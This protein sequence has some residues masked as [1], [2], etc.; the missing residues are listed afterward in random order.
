M[1]RSR[2]SYN[3]F[4]VSPNCLPQAIS[5]ETSLARARSLWTSGDWE[6]ALTALQQA[7][8]SFSNLPQRPDEWKALNDLFDFLADV[9]DA[10]RSGRTDSLPN[11]GLEKRRKVLEKVS[12]IREGLERILHGRGARMGI[13]RMRWHVRIGDLEK[14]FEIAETV[15]DSQPTAEDLEALMCPTDRYAR[16]LQP[17]VMYGLLDRLKGKPWPPELRYWYQML[18][19][20]LL[21]RLSWPEEA[22]LESGRLVRLPRRYAWMR[23]HRA[24]MLQRI[25]FDYAAAER[26]F[27]AVL[28]NVPWFW[29]AGACAAES[30]L[31]LGERA[32][33]LRMMGELASRLQDGDRA[34]CLC[35]RGAMRLWS[36]DYPGALADLD[37][38]AGQ[39]PLS[40]CWRG[41]AHLQLGHREEAQRDL[42]LC[43]ARWDN[44][45]E[46]LIWRGELKYR[47]GLWQEALKDFNRAVELGNSPFW[48]L[49]N[50]ALVK[51][52]LEDPAGMWADFY[53]I[54]DRIRTY[55][56]WREGKAMNKDS[57]PKEVAE[58]LEGVLKAGGG[59]RR[60]DVYLHPIW[61]GR[62]W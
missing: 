7:L 48:G 37:P 36:G 3:E 21:D 30:A 15:L 4:Q 28:R 34:A 5:S 14:A 22:F 26:E 29:K 45:Q 11:G 23:F 47:S 9:A 32:R 25:R 39:A 46:A 60:N 42:D 59:V 10:T 24:I 53:V 38:V 40:L 8:R 57:T 27:R 43:L 50:R 20:V 55:F 51:A 52:R 58:F 17:K 49:I 1:A 16:I 18:R 62:S 31:C 56:E 13:E 41:A 61:M 12:R 44:D 35:W 19:V 54:P 33:A 2:P 6:G